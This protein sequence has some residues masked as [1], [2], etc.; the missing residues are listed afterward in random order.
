[1]GI[2]VL[3]LGMLVTKRGPLRGRIGAP[4]VDLWLEVFPFRGWGLE[5]SISII[6]DRMPPSTDCNT[7]GLGL[8]FQDVRILSV[9]LLGV[10]FCVSGFG[11]QKMGFG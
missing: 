1:M 9:M 5:C 10:W 7:V 4:G 2:R 8:E 11:L 3:G 6:V